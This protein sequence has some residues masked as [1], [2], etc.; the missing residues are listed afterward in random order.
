MTTVDPVL[1]DILLREDL[2]A[3]QHQVDAQGQVILKVIEAVDKLILRD[4]VVGEWAHKGDLL[5]EN[6]TEAVREMRHELS[7]LIERKEVRESQTEA[8]SHQSIS[9]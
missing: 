7:L 1:N 3:L 4:Q 6:A 2:V 8:K 9:L 5:A